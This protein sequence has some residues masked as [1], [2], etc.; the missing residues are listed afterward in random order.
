MSDLLTTKYITIGIPMQD[1][2]YPR[3]DSISPAVGS[4]DG[5]TSITLSGSFASDSSGVTV[6][7]IAA[8]DFV[9][10]STSSITCTTPA[11]SADQH[12]VVVTSPTAGNTTLTNGFTAQAGA[13]A[14]GSFTLSV[15]EWGANRARLSF[16]PA[17]CAS[18]YGIYRN[19]EL[20][21]TI[22]NSFFYVD[23]PTAGTIEYL[24]KATNSFGSTDSNTIE[25][26]IGLGG[27][28][29]RA[30]QY[31]KDTMQADTDLDAYIET[32]KFNRTQEQFTESLCPLFVAYIDSLEQGQYLGV[33][34]QRTDTLLVKVSGK[35]ASSNDDADTELLKMDEMIR[36]ALEKTLQLAPAWFTVSI[37]NSTFVWMNDQIQEVNI[38]VR[39]QLPRFT[40]GTR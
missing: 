19:N 26:E 31:F 40:S 12:N 30:W 16:T 23:K 5:G 1:V 8:T 34:K 28:E 32:W 35:V 11:L 21:A 22:D 6:G 24:V 3:I 13:E 9:L 36:N 27:I 4:V 38:D 25:I 33:P 39:L 7:G 20:I 37:G 18:E 14:P 29:R 2:I 10:V 17:T 15:I